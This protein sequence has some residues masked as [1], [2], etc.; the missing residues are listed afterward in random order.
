MISS[1]LDEVAEGADRVYVLREGRTVLEIAG[2][3]ITEERILSAM[4][5]GHVAA[6]ELTP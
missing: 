2:E 6:P 3:D 5:Q 1:E 4:A